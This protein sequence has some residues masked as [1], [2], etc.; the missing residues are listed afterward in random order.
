[1][2]ALVGQSTENFTSEEKAK[3]VENFLK[4]NPWPGVERTVR[5]SIESIRNHAAWLERDRDSIKDF[6]S[7]I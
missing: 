1:M 3:D 6:L 5:Q 4:Q 7:K 2:I